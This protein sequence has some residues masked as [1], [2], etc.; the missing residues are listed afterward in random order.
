MGTPG[1][2]VPGRGQ[3]KLNLEHGRKIELPS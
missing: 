3:I 1:K 2:R